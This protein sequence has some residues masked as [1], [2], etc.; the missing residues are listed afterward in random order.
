VGLGVSNNFF[1]MDD[2]ITSIPVFGS[3]TNSGKK[4]ARTS[5]PICPRQTQRENAPERLIRI[6]PEISMARSRRW[7]FQFF[8]TEN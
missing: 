8:I 3:A 4:L 6:A 7:S 1:K 2:A 5:Q